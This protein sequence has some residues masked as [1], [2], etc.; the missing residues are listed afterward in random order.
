MVS[1]YKYTYSVFNNIDLKVTF[2]EIVVQGEKKKKWRWKKGNFLDCTGR[3]VIYSTSKL[4][5]FVD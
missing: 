4:I 2:L 3:T 5:V 1:C